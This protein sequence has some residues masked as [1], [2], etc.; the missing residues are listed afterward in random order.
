MAFPQASRAVA[1]VAAAAG[2]TSRSGKEKASEHSNTAASALCFG[3]V[4]IPP[5]SMFKLAVPLA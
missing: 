5:A 2:F 4:G 1:G 3:F